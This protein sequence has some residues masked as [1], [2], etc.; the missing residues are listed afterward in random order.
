[1]EN[2]SNSILAFIPQNKSG[3]LVIKEALYFQQI[4]EMRIFILNI[5]A[6]FL[7]TYLIIFLSY[8]KLIG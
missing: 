2:S 6:G 1:M 5:I 7:Y 8:L 3:E 4:L